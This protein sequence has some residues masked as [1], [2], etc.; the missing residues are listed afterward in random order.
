MSEDNKKNTAVSVRFVE[1]VEKQFG[2]EMGTEIIFSDHQKKLAQHLFLK[3]DSAL[4]EFES[5]RKGS[6]TPYTWN[7]VNLNNLAI[8][9]VHKVNLGLDALMKNHIHVIPYFNG[10]NKKYDLELQTGFKGLMYIA[11]KY[12][13]NPPKKI[14]IELVHKNDHFAVLKSNLEREVEGYEFEIEN[15]FNRGP[16]VGGF[17]YI[18]YEVETKNELMILTEEDFKKAKNAAKTDMIW[19]AWP[20]KMRYK[21]IARRV[22]DKIDLDPE[23]VNAQSM[24]HEETAGVEAEANREIAENANSQTIDIEA[25]E[26]EPDAIEEQLAREMD[27]VE[28]AID[29]RQSEREEEQES[30]QRLGATGTEG[31]RKPS[32]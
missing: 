13:L 20:E 7:N 18:K 5:K 28:E 31:P 25:E 32:F 16:V 10:K 3:A 14:V 30:E 6:K 15:P 4:K 12:A 9:A 2:Q 8:E 22:S 21:T 11:K 24:I 19:N 17:A 23:K 1:E 29:E 26:E 27:K